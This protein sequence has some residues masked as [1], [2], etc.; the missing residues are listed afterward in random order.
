MP[1]KQKHTKINGEFFAWTLRSRN[2]IW[3][4]DGRG[5]RINPG[6]HSLGTRDYDEA[7]EQLRQLDRL[8]AV[9]LGLATAAQ[10]R[11]ER[12]KLLSLEDGKRLYLE[13]RRLPRA[14]GGIGQK[15]ADRYEDVLDKFVPFAREA[16]LEYW[17]HLKRHH[18]T[19]YAAWLDAESYSYGTEYLELTTIKQAVNYFVREEHLPAD[20][21]IYMP[22][23]KPDGT[24]T[25]CYR[26]EEVTAIL[27][28][29][30]A[31][32]DLLWLHDICLCL[33]FT[34][35]RISELAALRWSD[36]DLVRCTITLKDETYTKR[37]KSDGARST[38]GKRTRS[39]PIHTKLGE[40]LRRKASGITT[41]GPVFTADDRE[42]WRA[43]FVRLA[44]INRV[45]TPLADTFPSAEEEVGFKDGRLHSFRHF[46]CSL[47]ANSGVPETVL[48]RW[49]GHKNSNM[50][51]HYYHLHDQ[52]SQ[53]QMSKITFD[54]GTGET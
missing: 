10:L 39:F 18:L 25:H 23:P 53:R 32:P 41:V 2:E 21:R 11:G 35:M 19:A 1:R 50:V 5:N 49:L 52:E 37:A 34:G 17:N 7:L 9:E 8:R 14:A 24:D 33:A 44:L 46:F 45:L 26:E 28:Y 12:G 42:K 22:L 6:R 47:C 20:C 54:P 38:K 51:R 16:G 40:M 15:S 31:Q 3:H 29:C 36:V 27:A 48:M 13:S 43:D 4:A 30:L